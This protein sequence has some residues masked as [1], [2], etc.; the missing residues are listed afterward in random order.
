MRALRLIS[1]SLLCLLTFAPARS[2]SLFA[3][4]APAAVE[5]GGRLDDFDLLALLGQGQFA[6][7]FLARQRSMQRLVALKVSACR[8]AEAE[9]LAQLDHPHI[10][11]VYDQRFLPDRGLLLV[12]MPYLA[13]GTLSDVLERA[14]AVPPE[15]RSGGT[16]LEAVDA[17]LE[18][19]GEL[20]PAASAARVAVS[21]HSATCAR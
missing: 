14:R 9:T 12:Y 20:P 11:R 2:T 16:L 1:L 15:R 8:A 5:P 3:A 18:R 17:A 4:R 6:R 19:R 13:G 7:V 21:C 10:V